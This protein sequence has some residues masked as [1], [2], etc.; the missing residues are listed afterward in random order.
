M[1]ENLARILMEHF[2]HEVEI[3]CYGDVEDP[4]NVSLECLDCGCVICDSDI[5]DL[6]GIV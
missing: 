5:Y 4:V 2:G 1:G 6:I 3:A